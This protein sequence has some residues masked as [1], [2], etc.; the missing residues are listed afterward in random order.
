[1]NAILLAGGSSSRFG[2]QNKV[3]TEIKG[4]K[5]I[6]RMVKKLNQVFA[7]TYVVVDDR[8][9]YSFLQQ[10]KV[11]TDIIPDKGPLGGLYTGLLH[12]ETQYNYLAAC[13]MP[14]IT[15]DYLQFLRR[16]SLGYDV[17]VPKHGGYLNPLAGIYNKRCWPHIKHQL[18]RGN[19][20]VK[21][22]FSQ[23]DVRLIPDYQLQKIG[24]PERLFFNLN[25]RRDLNTLRQL[26]E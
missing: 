16:Q 13:D 25:Y 14:L 2:S 26:A 12:S 18:N 17:L 3:L 6:N 4:Q 9:T 21:S 8:Q 20:K 19:L 22:F 7:Q 1:M 15:T 23:V 24:D 5:L 10:G 11:V